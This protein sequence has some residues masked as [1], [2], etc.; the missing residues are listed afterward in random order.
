MIGKAIP[1]LPARDFDATAA[2]YARIG[3]VETGRWHDYSILERDDVELHFFA[4]PDLDPGTTAGMAYIRVAD[5]ASLYAEVVAAGFEILAPDVLRE[6]FDGGG[7][8]ERI[9]ALEDKP[10]GLREFALLDVDNNLLRIGQ[11][12]TTAR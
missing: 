5:V 7:P 11:P 4:D 3:L 12:L 2:M 10:W 1:N 6:R 9:T 8:L